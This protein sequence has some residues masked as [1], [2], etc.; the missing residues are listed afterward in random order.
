MNYVQNKLKKYATLIQSKDFRTVIQDL[1][2]VNCKIFEGY[3]KSI[4]NLLVYIALTVNKSD[5]KDCNFGKEAHKLTCLIYSI[6][7]TVPDAD[8]F[9]SS[10]YHITRSLLAMSLYD[11]ASSVSSLMYKNSKIDIHYTFPKIATLWQKAVIQII[12][13]VQLNPEDSILYNRFENVLAYELSIALDACRDYSKYMLTKLN[14]Y[15]DEITK[16]GKSSS[17]VFFYFCDH[18]VE[19][20][21]RDR[22]PMM[23]NDQIAIFKL[24]INILKKITCGSINMRNI[25]KGVWI[26]CELWNILETILIE[27]NEYFKCAKQFKDLCE[28]FLIPVKDFS[29]N[30]LSFKNN[31]LRKHSSNMKNKNNCLLTKHNALCLIEVS[32]AIFLYYEECLKTEEKNFFHDS[33]LVQIMNL[34]E[35]ISTVCMKSTANKHAS[36][37]EDCKVK[38]DFYHAIAIRSKC[39]ALISKLPAKEISKEICGITCQFLEEN[40]SCLYMLYESKCNTWKLLWSVCGILIYNMGIMLSSHYE[41]SSL[42]FSLLC[43]SIIR[44]E[45]VQDFSDYLQLKNPFNIALHRLSNVHYNHGMYREAMTASAL[46]GLLSYDN[47]N[48]KAFR[49]WAVIKHKCCSMENIMGISMLTCLKEDIYKIKDIGLNI[50]LSQYNVAKLGLREVKGLYEAKVNLSSAIKVVIKELKIMK[51]DYFQYSSA[52]Q[53]LGHH[54]LYF[55]S[56]ES[57]FGL[58]H[59]ALLCLKKVKRNSAIISCL[60]ANLLFYICVDKLQNINKETKVEMENMNYTINATNPPNLE[61]Q[62][63]DFQEIVPTYRNLNIN[64]DSNLMAELKKPLKVWEDC[65]STNI[66]EIVKSG[67]PNLTL[68]NIITAAEYSRLLRYEECEGTFWNLAFKL[69][70]QLNDRRALIYVIGR[71]IS[72][73]NF[74]QGRINL[75]MKYSQELKNSEDQEIISVIAIFWLS[76][77]D[78]YYESKR[79]LEGKQLIDNARDLPGISLLHNTPIYLLSLDIILKNCKQ[80]HN[81]LE[82]KKYTLLIVES[83]YSSIILSDSMAATKY[84]PRYK[85]L[86]NYDVLFS[87]TV[88]LSLRMNSLTAFREI[89]VY[90]HRRL[91]SAQSMGA[92][93]RAAEILKSMCL[94]DLSR[95]RLNDCEAKLQGLEH[96]LNLETF[97]SSLDVKLLTSMQTL[98]ISPVQVADSIRDLPRNDAS[99]ILRKKI[100][101]TPGFL[102]HKNCSCYVCQNI[103]YQYLVFTATYIRAQLFVLQIDYTSALQ[104]FHGAFEIRRRLC[105]IEKPILAQNPP[106]QEED[107]KQY[108]W[109]S[110]YFMVDYVLLLLNFSHFLKR[111]ISDKKEESLRIALMAVK[112]CK[113]HGLESHPIY[114][115]AEEHVLT[116]RFQRVVTNTDF[117]KF[118]VPDLSSIDVSKYAESSK[119][120]NK[121]CVT[122]TVSTRSKKKPLPVKHIKSPPLVKLMDIDS[123]FTDEVQNNTVSETCNKFEG[124]ITRSRKKLVK[125]KI[126]D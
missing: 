113:T 112:T 60:E 80:Y 86:F 18:L 7:N 49:M 115:D 78:F 8:K 31:I 21:R 34:I 22:I 114:V 118:T 50:E 64:E 44:F 94:I 33:F 19:I 108:S 126:F 76:L 59:S 96:M 56:N 81:D 36:C 103:T 23:E 104:H 46:N 24:M 106:L 57:I 92:M 87:F 83:I 77:A 101:T 42:L 20:L 28:I 51:V 98:K 91:E 65:F 85:Q 52:I 66:D 74:S 125:R 11:E 1:Q 35:S 117:L 45:G 89:S 72:L 116:D 55:E 73:R 17:K 41:S 121:V 30:N 61:G 120:D 39:I 62:Q 111:N 75:A 93:I 105:K 37:K 47:I 27:D 3:D 79:F 99:P 119:I 16:A 32:E 82:K 122:P 40:I 5:E 54:S 107:I 38:F 63:D 100:F 25:K 124:R 58:L 90:L 88:N 6:L 69:A 102:H 71:S 70:H 68:Q 10:M 4:F 14:T 97:D 9:F 123:H 43:S 53:Y 110:R 84:I 2:E 109:Q 67:D 13:D 15:L 29:V 48:S 95:W 12:N 26:L